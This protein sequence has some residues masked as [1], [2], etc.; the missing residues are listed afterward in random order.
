MSDFNKIAE[1]APQILSASAAHL[2]K[3]ASENV[4]LAQNVQALE[5]QLRLHKLA[6]R[7]EDRGLEPQ[8]NFEEK[9]AHLQDVDS[10]RLD[11]LEQ[12]VELSAGGFKLGSL[13]DTG[14]STDTPPAPGA[15]Y[16]DLDS[17]IESG[18]AL[19]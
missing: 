8:Y 13:H 16:T 18:G 2:R 11:S 14:E 7:M 12:A 10:S 1:Q 9:L 5:H 19:A 3:L 4:K 6:R 15:T 17:Y